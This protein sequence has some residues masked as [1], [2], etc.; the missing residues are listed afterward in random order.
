[1]RKPMMSL[2]DVDAGGVI[3]AAT[4]DP[5]RG[6]N[7]HL[8]TTRQVMRVHLTYATKKPLKIKAARLSQMSYF[9]NSHGKMQLIGSRM[10]SVKGYL[11]TAFFEFLPGT[12][13]AGIVTTNL[14]TGRTCAR[15]NLVNCSE[16]SSKQIV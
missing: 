14:L 12:A 5:W 15:T 16:M 9:P 10:A 1:M 3:L 7:V 11:T 8:E 4:R 6:K 2:R 13:R